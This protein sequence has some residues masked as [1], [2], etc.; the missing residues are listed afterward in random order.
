MFGAYG[1]SYPMLAPVLFIALA[2]DGWAILT[3]IREGN[4]SVR[5]VLLW[6]LVLIV[7]PYGGFALWRYWWNTRKGL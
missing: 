2:F 3:M 4:Q 7:I 1:L 5:T 6:S